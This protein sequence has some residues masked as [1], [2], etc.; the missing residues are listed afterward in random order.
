M[1]DHEDK[2]TNILVHTL[3][4]SPISQIKIAPHAPACRY[5]YTRQHC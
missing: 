2:H 3:I 5:T 1:L 4:L